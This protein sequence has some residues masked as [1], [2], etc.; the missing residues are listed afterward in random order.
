MNVYFDKNAMD[1]DGVIPIARVKPHTCFRAPIESGLCKMLTIGL[2]KQKGA[3]ACHQ[4]TFKY[5][6]EMI[7][8]A[9]QIKLGTG[10]IL[11]GIAVVENAYDKVHTIR[12]VP[13]EQFFEADRELLML[14]RSKMAKVLFNPIDV[15]VLR[16][17]GKDVSGDGYDPNVVGKPCS[18]FVEDD[19][20]FVNVAGILDLT[21]GTHG[22]SSGIGTVEVIT[23]R[24]YDK[25]DFRAMY[26]NAITTTGLGIAK[27]PMVMENDKEAIMTLVSA[28]NAPSDVK[29]RMVI[30]TDSLHVSEFYIS[31]AMLPDAKKDGRIEVLSEPF[32]L[33]FDEKGVLLLPLQE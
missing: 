29:T 21:D 3:N 6:Y 17:S 33:E 7:T 1:S 19:N 2:G 14:A 24:L 16:R 28:G 13:S 4:R 25:I 5:M 26:A 32:E 31:E 10:K 15:L 8:K 23:K 9:A 30:I 12:A 18:K 20:P 22:N 27:V 11:F